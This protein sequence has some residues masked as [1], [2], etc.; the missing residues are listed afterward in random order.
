MPLPGVSLVYLGKND[1]DKEM[2]NMCK[3]IAVKL[4]EAQILM[5]ENS[6][7]GQELPKPNTIERNELWLCGHSRF[8]EANTNVR[9]LGERNLGGFDIKDVA[10]FLMLCIT[11]VGVKKIRL[12]CCESAQEQRHVPN[13]TG[14]PPA[15]L[16]KVIGNE[17]LHTLK[18]GDKSG[19]RLFR[20]LEQFDYCK[21][22]PVDAHLSHL[23]MLIYAIAV[24]MSEGRIKSHPAFE[25]CGLWGAG[26][27]TSDKTPITSFLQE[28]GSLEAQ[29]KM[30][31]KSI[32]EQNRLTFKRLFEDAHCAKK[33]L[34]DF[35]GYRVEHNLLINW[36]HFRSQS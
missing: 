16:S 19:S 15:G 34:P 26:D 30:D 17:L 8:I 2:L 20:M 10:E 25:I 22:S 18:K 35:F 1:D 13:V 4:R 28:K 12:I 14:V 23:E 33:G 9:K 31:N 6:D 5:Q 24:S 32:K 7:K 36:M 11:Q 27:I 29:E 21:G 3:A